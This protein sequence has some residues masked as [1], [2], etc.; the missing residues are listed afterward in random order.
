VE[1]SLGPKVLVV[2]VLG[3]TGSLAEW[4][5]LV[6]RFK[7][8]P[9]VGHSDSIVYQP[10]KSLLSVGNAQDLANGLR[11]RIDEK[12]ITEGESYTNVILVGHS[13]GGL[14]VRKAY[15]LACGAAR[16][17]HTSRW[18]PLVSHIVLFAA[19]NRGVDARRTLRMRLL[20]R[21]YRAARTFHAIPHLLL[22]DALWGSAF[23]TQ[24]RLEW[25]RHFRD[26]DNDRLPEV[27][28]LL[29]TRDQLVTREDSTDLL[30]FPKVTAFDVADATHDNLHR[31]DASED[32]A[33]RYKLLR[34]AVFEPLSAPEPELP[35]RS[36]NPVIFVLHGIRA[37][38][39][40][41]PD[42]LRELL[43]N[44]NTDAEVILP[45]YNYF[46]ALNFCL[47][48]IRRRYIEWFQD[49]YSEALARSSQSD[50]HFVG[51]SNGTYLLGASLKALPAMRFQRI[52]LIGSVLP[53]DYDWSVRVRD[54]QVR[55]IRN[56]RSSVDWPVGL[57]CSGLRAL[58]M[59]DIGTGGFDGFEW[60]TA[61]VSR[62]IYYHRGGHS[63]PLTPT[64]L[65]DIATH[66]L[67]GQDPPAPYLVPSPP[68]FFSW[69]SRLLGHWWFTI[70]LI[71]G[72]LAI[73]WGATYLVAMPFH[74][75]PQWHW[76]FFLGLLL[77]IAIVLATV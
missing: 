18:H 23:L 49:A 6:D 74:L 21:L 76:T 48:W 41:W 77:V 11:A 29:G 66:I 68:F 44:A 7:A 72:V 52:A 43:L 25:I 63:G 55:E 71:A 37:S 32:P 30:Q 65:T 34:H 50:F 13:F 69:A 67:T 54:G 16:G 10:K 8:D 70:P 59:R 61:S 36:K 47:P 53:R 62:E 57:L 40:G 64:C 5:E 28:Q 1:P 46:S 39:S 26:V 2:Y 73:A 38:N 31:P 75:P 4:N 42:Q 12:W 51:H 9:T 58:Q 15:L 35:P 45:S 24:L 56:H 17:T 14:L 19:T 27:V 60:N 3:L 33:S 22:S 20:R